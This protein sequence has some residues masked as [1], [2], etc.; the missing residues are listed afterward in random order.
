MYKQ[1][2]NNKTEAIINRFM[3]DYKF[4]HKGVGNAALKY[5]L[6]YFKIQGVK[7][8]ILMIDDNNQIAKNLYCALG[9]HFTG[10]IE[11]NEYYYVLELE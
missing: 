7:K 11:K 9:F 10:K 2:E 4:Q 5:I 6:Q 3:L 1:T 8:I